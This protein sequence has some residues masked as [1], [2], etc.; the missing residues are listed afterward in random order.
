MPFQILVV[1]IRIT[2]VSTDDI[3]PISDIMGVIEKCLHH[4]P[5]YRCVGAGYRNAS[6][7]RRIALRGI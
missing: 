3:D 4:I 2:P 5:T 7:C 1:K 6:A